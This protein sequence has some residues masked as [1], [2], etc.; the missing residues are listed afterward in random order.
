VVLGLLLCAALGVGWW[1]LQA[2]LPQLDGR[3][4]TAAEGPRADVLIERDAD[5]APTVRGES[6]A[7][8]A[9]GVGFLHAQDRFFQMDLAR[10][11][12]AGGVSSRRCSG[13]GHWSATNPCACFACDTWR[14]R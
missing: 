3:F 2:S 6:L 8:V 13:S 9:W 11:M 1:A 4:E 14:G 5:G 7:D 10:R 12:A